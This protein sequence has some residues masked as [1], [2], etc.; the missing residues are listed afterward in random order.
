MHLTSRGY[1]ALVQ[2][3]RQQQRRTRR[4]HLGNVLWTPLDLPQPGPH[5]VDL[6]DTRMGPAVQDLWMLVSTD[7]RDRGWQW[8]CLLDGYEQVRPFDRAELNWVEP[9]RTLRIIHYSAWLARRVDDPAFAQ[10]F[11]WFGS[12]AYWNEQT[13]V[14]LEQAEACQQVRST[15]T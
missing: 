6:D 8:A 1:N 10:H 3:E 12:P 2:L 15:F 7:P 9:L 5:F 14:L 11:P 13:Q 4:C